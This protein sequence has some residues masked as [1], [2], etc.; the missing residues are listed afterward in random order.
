MGENLN[1]TDLAPAL[2]RYFCASFAPHLADD[3]VQDTLVRLINK[4]SNDQFDPT[5]G[6]LRMYSFGIAHFVRLEALRSLE[7]NSPPEDENAAS[8][9]PLPD[10]HLEQ[11]RQIKNLRKAIRSLSEVQQQV[12]GL[13]LDKELSYEEIA[14]ILGLPMGTVKSHINRAKEELKLALTNKQGA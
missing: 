4:I 5:R 1:V 12:I 3:L 9:A 6:N 8:L 13:Y 2:Y 14:L 7:L 11:N 10:E